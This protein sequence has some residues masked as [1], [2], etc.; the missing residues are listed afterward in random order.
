MNLKDM[1][2]WDGL[3]MSQ[4]AINCGMRCEMCWFLKYRWHLKRSGRNFSDPMNLGT[5]YHRLMKE[6]QGAEEI[7]KDYVRD[8]QAY[9]E[10]L[11]AAGEEMDDDTIKQINGLTDLYQ[12]A[13]TMAQLFWDTYPRGEDRRTLAREQF[14]RI[15]DIE[16]TVDEIEIYL[17]TGET[18]L[19]DTK[20]TGRNLKSVLTGY[21]YGL[22]LRTYRFLAEGW[23]QENGHRPPSG[24]IVDAVLMPAIKLCRTDLKKAKIDGCTPE[25]A[26]RQRVEQWYIDKGEKAMTSDA[27]K[28]DEPLIPVELDDAFETIRE[29][30]TRPPDPVNYQRDITRSYCYAYEKQCPFYSLCCKKPSMW[31]VELDEHFEVWESEKKGEL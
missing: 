31:A 21:E 28:F 2:C 30:A 17:P 16:G 10:G 20:T 5:I 4:S 12:K 7:T 3:P 14:I 1:E 8:R 27:M 22:Q 13:E 6:G 11:Y 23:C 19:R 24:F 29:L 18:V 15:D 25:E 9:Y 26:Y